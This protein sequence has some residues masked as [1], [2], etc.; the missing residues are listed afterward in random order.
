MAKQKKNQERNKKKPSRKLRVVRKL[1][2]ILLTT[3]LSIFLIC[4]ITGTIVAS[5]VAVYVLNFM[6]E[7]STVTLEEMELS[8]NTNIYGYDEDGKLETLYQVTN[9]VQRFPVKIEQIPQHTIDAFVYTEDER[10][11]T[12]DGVDYKNTIAACVNMVLHF[13]DSERGGSTITQQLIKNVTGEDTRS[14]SRKIREIF[15]AMTLEKNYSKQKIIETY[16]NYIGFGGSANGI[17][18]ASIKYFGKDVEDLTIAE[19]AVLASIPQSPETINPFAGYIDDITGEKINTGRER[20]RE[21]QEYVLWQMYNHGA[22]SYD[23]YQ[24]ALVEHIIYTDTDEYE[25]LHPELQAK[26]Y[27]PKDNTSWAVDAAILEVEDYLMD[28]YA[29]DRKTALDK[30]NS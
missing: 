16:L 23:E 10:F 4:L 29:I 25:Q 3:L 5:A 1:I 12:H 2:S 26:E 11:Y 18:M 13:W 27:N 28:T 15:R 8:Y 24:E 22:I 20:N 9:A 21:R 14:P 30:I 6:D 17:Q 7:A 19:S